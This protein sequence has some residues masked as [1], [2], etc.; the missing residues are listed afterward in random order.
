MSHSILNF[1]RLP[2]P[3]DW[4][5]IYG[6]KAPI[7]LDLGF[8]GGESLVAL[9]QD[10]TSSNV[11]GV[12]ISLPSLK[13][14]AKKVAA[15]E[16]DNARV[17]QGD[18]LAVLWL[19]F[20]PQS[21]SGVTINFP[22]PWPK[23]GHQHRRVISP[24]F[25]DLLATRM[26]SGAPL[27][28]ATDHEEYAIAIEQC[29]TQ[30]PYFESR[31]DQPYL[32]DVENRKRTKYERIALSEGRPPRYFL[33]RRNS[34]SA[35]DDFPIPEETAVP[36]IVLLSSLS[37]EEVGNRFEPFYVQEDDIHIK[38]LNI[39]HNLRENMLLVELYVSEEPYRQRVALSIR[40]RKAG[41]FVLSLHEL[42][43]PRPTHGIHLAVG[44]LAAWLREQDP[45]LTIIN[46]TLMPQSDSADMGSALDISGVIS[47]LDQ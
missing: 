22:D 5:D 34:K 14:G 25:L 17:L 18:S 29:L 27:D 6:R 39:Y 8:G 45:D 20:L 38:Y 42:G 19:Y 46:S 3:T 21:I 1:A 43:F 16:L 36:H 30:S 35:V 41:D 24:R 31:Y 40:E 23:S 4:A 47:P 32:P 11:L 37:L 12:E 10:N 15:A 7:L 44:H 26:L 28:I 9:A 13:R 33:W 2:W